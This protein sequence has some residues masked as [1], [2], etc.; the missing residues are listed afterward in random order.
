MLYGTVGF[1]P[2]LKYRERFSAPV[3]YALEEEEHC[4]HRHYFLPI[5]WHPYSLIC[6]EAAEVEVGARSNSS[7]RHSY[8]HFPERLSCY[9]LPDLHCYDVPGCYLFL[10]CLLSL[11]RLRSREREAVGVDMVVVGATLLFMLRLCGGGGGGCDLGLAKCDGAHLLS[12]T[13]R[14][15]RGGG[16]FLLLRGNGAVLFGQGAPS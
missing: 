11:E 10:G 6:E 13:E 8:W 1:C 15:W 5:L 14:S 4:E 2:R 16:T 9:A 7:W 12:R 3:G